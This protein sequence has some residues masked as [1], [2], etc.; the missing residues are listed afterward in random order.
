MS[1]RKLMP[2]DSI[3]MISELSA[4]FDVKK[5]TAMKVNNGLNR[6]AK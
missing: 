2:L 5:M 4:S 1:R 6:F 3:A